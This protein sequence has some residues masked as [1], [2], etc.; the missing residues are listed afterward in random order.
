MQK[1]HLLKFCQVLSTE[2]YPKVYAQDSKTLFPNWKYKKNFFEN[3]FLNVLSGI[4]SH[5]AHQKGP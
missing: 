2:K 4:K 3:C 5:S 1:T